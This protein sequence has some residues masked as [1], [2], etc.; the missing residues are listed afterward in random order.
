MMI[1]IRTLITNPQQP[2]TCKH[3]RYEYAVDV[4]S[5]W[6]CVSTTR[7]FFASPNIY[8]RILQYYLYKENVQAAKILHIFTEVNALIPSHAA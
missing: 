6:T 7:N 1:T 5:V 8:T 3:V 4:H 2:N